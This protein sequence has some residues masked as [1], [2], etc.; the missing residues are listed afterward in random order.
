MRE[1]LYYLHTNGYLIHKNIVG[2][3]VND[4]ID[5]PF[6]RCYWLLDT[7][8]RLSAWN[9]LVEALSLGA[10]KDRINELCSRWGCDNTDAEIYA[11]T[12]G[13]VVGMD[14]SSHYARTP[15]FTNLQEDCCGFGDTYLE[16]MADLCKQLGF[17][18]Y[19]SFEE[20]LKSDREE[21]KK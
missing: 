21:V 5:S 16:A 6:V 11:D 10:N 1:H 20:L 8:S 4:Y 9:L 17:K 18:G 7:E 2:K 3:N 12:I 19:K 15:Q 13:V 14:G